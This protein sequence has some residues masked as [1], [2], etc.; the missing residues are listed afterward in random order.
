MQSNPSIDILPVIFGLL[1]GLALFLYGIEQ[2]TGALKTVAGSKMKNLLG[3]MTSNRFKGALTGAFATAI[4]QSSSVTTVLVVGFISA[5]LISLTQAISIIVGAHVGSTLTVQ[6]IAFNVTEYSLLMVAFGFG[7]RFIVKNEKLKYLGLMLMGFGLIFLG[8]QFMS[9]ATRPLRTY[10]PFINS[11]SQMKNPLI[12][13][14]AATVFTAIIQSSAAT[15]GI[16]IALASQ[17]FINLE[18]GIS[19]VFGANIGTCVT[20][21][22]ASIGNPRESKQAALS[23]IIINIIGVLLWLPFIYQL[24]DLVRFLSPAFPGLKDIDRIAAEAPR[25][26]ANAH[27]IFNFVNTLILL[28]LI[29][30]LGKFISWILPV[31]PYVTLEKIKPKYLDEASLT[32]PSIALELVR[33]ELSRQS[34]R[35]LV[36]IKEIAD[37]VLFS[38]KE[39]LKRIK[40]MDDDVDALHE[41]IIE[42]LSKLSKKELSRNESRLMQ[43]YIIASNYIEYIGDVI[44]TNLVTLGR[45]RVRA[46]IEFSKKSEP[47]IRDFFEK[48][49]WCAEESFASLIEGNPKKAETVIGMKKEISDLA[50]V[51]QLHLEKRLNTE[52]DIPLAEYRILSEIVENMK[53]IYY[54]SKRIAKDVV[55]SDGFNNAFSVKPDNEEL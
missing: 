45:E 39:K 2:M 6:I 27:T 51:T 19:L 55:E 35:A 40:K 31:K 13:I 28:P 22:L 1:G 41:Y 54:L 43:S 11:M 21:L 23:H 20:A 38:D 42:Y 29:T 16:V 18:A 37:S 33:M 15:I 32:T 30:P 52:S 17:G 44:E 7:L 26:I 12:G 47:Y 46:E 24:D 36:M 49:T 5:G 10:Q 34:R 50:E 48:V 9:D 25:Q 53:R 4:V 8:M 14:L 3:R